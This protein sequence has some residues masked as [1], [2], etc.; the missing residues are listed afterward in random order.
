MG[1]P[2]HIL[3]I[4]AAVAEELYG[5]Q[6]PVVVLDARDLGRLRDGATVRIEG[7]RVE[8]A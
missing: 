2:D 8:I 4:G 5:V 1:E 3:A 7:D 6:V